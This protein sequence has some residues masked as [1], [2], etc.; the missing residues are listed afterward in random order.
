MSSERL[1]TPKFYAFEI[2]SDEKLLEKLQY[3][4]LNPVR[5]GL[6][7]KAVDWKWG[8]ARWYEEQKSVGVP[9]EWAP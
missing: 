6:V 1:W 5:A 9:T 3:M 8:S 4:P 2:Y 7:E